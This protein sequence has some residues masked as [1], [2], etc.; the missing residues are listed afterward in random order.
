[1]SSV[2]R[3]ELVARL[4]EVSRVT[5][6]RQ[7]HRDRAVPL[8]QLSLEVTEHDRERARDTVAELERLGVFQPPGDEPPEPSEPRPTRPARDTV[9]DL[10][11]QP[12]TRRRR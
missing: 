12:L 10:W 9:T 11:G 4:A 1:V 7:E 2:S 8:Q 3:E 5:S 6:V